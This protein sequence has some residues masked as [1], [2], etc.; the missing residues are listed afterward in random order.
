MWPAI[1]I[2]ARGG[3]K[4]GEELLILE[5]IPPVLDLCGAEH[6]VVLPFAALFNL[7]SPV[8]FPIL[9]TVVSPR[10]GYLGCDFFVLSPQIAAV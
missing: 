2:V 7:V 3:C 5:E 10:A 9:L 6:N 8:V 1:I 4:R